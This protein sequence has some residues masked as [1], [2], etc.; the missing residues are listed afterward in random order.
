MGTV[1]L[2]DGDLPACHPYGFKSNW[3]VSLFVEPECRGQGVARHL[4]KYAMEYAKN[5]LNWRFIWLYTSTMADA[6]S[7]YGF[8]TIEQIEAHGKI[9]HVMRVDLR[10]PTTTPEEETPNPESLVTVAS[11]SSA[12]Q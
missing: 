4:M 11:S 8:K 7:R 6:Y 1:T 3:L 9:Q 5:E 12:D 10:S 2:D